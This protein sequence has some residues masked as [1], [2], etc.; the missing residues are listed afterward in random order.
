[1]IAQILCIALSVYW[2]MLFIRII[3]S[4]TT[5]FWSPPAYLGAA[6][7]VIHDLTEPVLGP[8]RRLIPPV[9][10]LDFS[11]IIV[12]IAIRIAQSQVC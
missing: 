6:V 10:G 12:F 5:Q 11:P 8:L 7:K 2:V 3:L 4:F 9:G 1:M